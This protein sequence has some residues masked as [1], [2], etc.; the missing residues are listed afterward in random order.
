V[1][2]VNFEPGMKQWTCCDRGWEWWAGGRCYCHEQNTY[3]SW[4]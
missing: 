4:L 2:K 3:A 1:E